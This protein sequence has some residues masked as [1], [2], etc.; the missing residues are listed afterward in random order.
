MKKTSGGLKPNFVKL[1]STKMSEKKK[2]KTDGVK[3]VHKV[4][5]SKKE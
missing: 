3:L 4:S 5:G 1:G 2:V